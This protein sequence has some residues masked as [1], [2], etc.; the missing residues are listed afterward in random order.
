MK[1]LAK[2]FSLWLP[3]LLVSC[4]EIPSETEALQEDKPMESL[5]FT[6]VNLDDMTDFQP[7]AKNWQTVGDAYVDLNK[8]RTFVASP[9]KGIL[10]NLPEKGM[11]DNL[12]TVFEHGDIELEVDV[13]MPIHSNSGLYFQ[14]RYEV[15]LLDSWGEKQPRHGDMGGIYQR[16]D[17]TK[18]K[19]SRGYE[20]HPPAV[21]AAKAPGLWQHFKIKF[22]APKFDTAGKKVKNAWFEEVWLNGALLHKNQEITG[23]T[24]AAAFQDEQAMGPLMIQGDHGPVAFK[25]MKYKLFGDKQVSIEDMTMKTYE[26]TSQ[27]IPDFDTLTVGSEINADSISSA[28]ATGQNPRKVLV[29]DGKMVIP[30]AG[31]Y[32]FEFAIHRGGGML[33]INNDTIVDLNGDF[34]MAEPGFGLVSLPQG[35]VP[36]T[37]IYN[38]HRPYQRGFTLSVEGPGIPKQGLH[39][40]QS[41]ISGQGNEPDAIVIKALDETVLQRSFL[42]HRGSKRTHC[43]SVATPEGINYAVDLAFGSLIQTWNDGFLD[44]TKMWHARGG[45][46]LGT[47]IGFPVL[48]IH[49]YPDF[50]LLKNDKTNW[51]DSIPANVTYKQLGYRL[52]RQ[53]APTFSMALDGSVISYKFIPSDTIRQL[54]RI[55]STDADKDIWHK[56][57]EGTIIDALPDNIYAIDDKNY[58]VDFS[59]NENLTPTIRQASGKEELL[60]KIPKGSHMITY[61]ITW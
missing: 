44:A 12:F 26:S 25:N 50:A 52:D 61:T 58:F 36:F 13:M 56:L 41:V 29:Y 38:K 34:S 42:M 46:Q 35:A 59:G 4:A 18:E 15:Q 30:E 54:E 24:R 51:P 31:D 22:H 33:L 11:K 45:Q 2:L 48:S 57:G 17:Q 3:Y 6:R 14:G 60:I 37:L 39:A 55:I 16:W 1:Q 40:P 23:P 5:P 21:N 32:L 47:P 7:V 20:G 43:I 27:T 19:G 53:G 28:M 49:G 9:G 10:L 8:K